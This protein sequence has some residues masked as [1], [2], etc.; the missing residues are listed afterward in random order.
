MDLID[1][2]NMQVEYKGKT[3][4]YILSLMD[5]FSRFHWLA[6]LERKKSSL[7]KKELQRIYSV[8][9]KPE[10]LQSDNGRE[11]KKEVKSYCVKNK[12]KMIKCRP[13]HP[14][15]QGKV[16]RSHRVLR[17]KIYYDLMKQKKTGVNWVKC[18]PD[19][20]KCLNHDKREELSWKSAFE[21]YYGRKANELINEGRNYNET[22][23]TA[24]TIGPSMKSLGNQE[25]TRNRWRQKAKEADLRMA[26]RMVGKDSRKIVYKKYA[27]GEKVFVRVGS[28]RRCSS[29]THRVLPGTILK[30]YKDDV[31]YKIQIHMSGSNEICKQTFRIEDIADRPEKKKSKKVKKTKIFRKNFQ[32]KMRIPLTQSDRLQQFT[33]QAFDV[34]DNPPG[35]GNCQFSAICFALRNFGLH[36]SPETLRTE[37]LQDLNNNDMVEGIPLELFAGIPWEKYLRQMETDGTYGDE[38]TL[39]AIPTYS[40][41]E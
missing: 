38:I 21:I 30:P 4:R 15:S 33:N 29:K 11:F 1:M 31:T 3:Y 22:I 40:M 24:K 35:D 8:H 2:K 10:R 26:I 34:V 36:R 14:Q 5:L 27:A 25:R 32:E 7:V 23:C 13:Y 28:K 9:G 19:Y 12:I 16:E 39:Q 17:R 37:V 41:L 6:P 18:L 20:M